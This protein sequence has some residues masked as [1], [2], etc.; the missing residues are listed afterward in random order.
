MKYSSTTRLINLILF[1]L[2]GFG[3]GALGIYFGLC[4][5][6]FLWPKLGNLPNMGWGLGA[7]LGV[8]GLSAFIVCVYG[9]V[10][11]IL[12]V[13]KERDD[14]LVRKAFGCYSALGYLAAAFFL[15]NATWLYRLTSTNIGYSDFA[16]VIVVYVVLFLVFGIV[17]NIPLLRMYGESEELNKIMRILAGTLFALNF[18][19]LLVFGISYIVLATHRDVYEGAAVASHLGYASLVFIISTLLSG[20]AF[21]GYARADKKG[22]IKKAN[23]FLFEGALAVDG[24]AMILAGVIEYLNQS[25]KKPS[26]TSLVAKTVQNTNIYFMEFSVMAFILGG[27]LILFSLYLCWNTFKGNEKK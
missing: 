11:S 16:F 23:G 25:P 3:A 21:F 7:L 24:G 13:I 6:P 12:S 10:L 27:L 4:V 19:L 8:T 1:A 26:G 9:L 20:A 18:A 17:S 14:S 22:V 5:T 15:L 2:L